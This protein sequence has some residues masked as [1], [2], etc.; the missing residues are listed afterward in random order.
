M[1][2]YP[3]ALASG[4]ALAAA[5]VGFTMLEEASC[6]WPIPIKPARIRITVKRRE[7]AMAAQ[8]NCQ[9]AMVVA[10]ELFREQ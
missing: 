9:Q 10:G 2:V 5:V 4:V 8:E 1:Y 7:A 6:A 3:C